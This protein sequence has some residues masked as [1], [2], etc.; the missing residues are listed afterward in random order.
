MKLL[1]TSIHRGIMEPKMVDN[2][3]LKNFLEEDLEQLPP[4]QD[5]DGKGA[6]SRSNGA[7]VEGN[8][9]VIMKHLNSIG[10][11]NAIKG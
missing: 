10:I 3:S 6:K 9:D 5:L 8:T 7:G 1:V 11:E 4:V 2:E